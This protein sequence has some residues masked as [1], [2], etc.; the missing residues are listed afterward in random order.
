MGQSSVKEENVRLNVRI[1]KS[2]NIKF[3]IL[4]FAPLILVAVFIVIID[5]FFH[6]H[7]P[8]KGLPYILE[9]ERYQNDGIAKHF[10]YEILITGSSL[11]QN[12]L[13]SDAER[14]W[15][16]KAVKTS[17]AGGSFKEVDGL[18]KTAAASNG[19]L[20]LVIRGLDITRLNEKKDNYDYEDI[21]TFLYDKNPLNDF[22]YLFNQDVMETAASDIKRLVKKET[23][24]S[25][26]DYSNW[27]SMKAFGK[28]AVLATFERVPEGEYEALV[29]DDAAMENLRANIT[30]NV[31]ETAVNNPDVD[32]YLFFP[33]V[34]VCYWD[35]AIRTG[36]YDYTLDTLRAAA[37]IL[38]DH[39]NIKLFGFD[40]CIDITGNLDNYMDTL[41]YSQ[42]INTFILESMASDEHRLTKD[43]LEEYIKKVDNNYRSYD[44]D[45]IFE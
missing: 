27:N 2:G 29:F 24:T 32:F 38:L 25:F 8:L 30:Q 22:K 26:D 23:P 1:K 7:A 10:D 13:A 33:P 45:S 40:D 42:E 44:Y 9:E 18:V 20:K 41:H 19:D 36:S 4:V 34:S 39:E 16:E 28:E 12:F 37:E 3:F 14:L 35:A 5:P 43:N 21:P 6:Y 15:G 11:T 17:F 31:I